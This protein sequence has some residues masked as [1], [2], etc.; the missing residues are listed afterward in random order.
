M[1]TTISY[2]G[3]TSARGIEK[4]FNN[5]DNC[6]SSLLPPPITGCRDI[7]DVGK[8]KFASVDPVYNPANT[9]EE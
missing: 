2:G 8:L 3:R 9:I 1:L 7:D 5:G 6:R 4:R